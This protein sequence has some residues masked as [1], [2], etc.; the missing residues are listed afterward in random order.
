MSND[1]IFFL[2]VIKYFDNI[3]HFGS[4]EWAKWIRGKKFVQTINAVTIVAARNDHILDE[5]ICLTADATCS[6]ISNH[7]TFIHQ[8]GCKFISLLQ[9]FILNRFKRSNGLLSLKSWSW[10]L[11]W[12]SI[13][14]KW[15]LIL[16]WITSWLHL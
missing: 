4:T 6:I 9:L 1:S 2:N 14:L 12:C 5:F 11:T 8:R 16:I 13:W 15:L 3:L 7:F 10:I